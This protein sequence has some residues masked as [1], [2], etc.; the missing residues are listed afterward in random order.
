MSRQINRDR[1]GGGHVPSGPG[2]AGGWKGE[3]I[4]IYFYLCAAYTGGFLEI[5]RKTL[6]AAI[7]YAASC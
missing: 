5:E 4:F 7:T 3:G 2:G 6:E 1:R